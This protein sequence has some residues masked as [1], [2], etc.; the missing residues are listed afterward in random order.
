MYGI[1]F[2]TY[3]GEKADVRDDLESGGGTNWTKGY[4]ALGQRM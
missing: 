3:S 1:G 4:V 2:G